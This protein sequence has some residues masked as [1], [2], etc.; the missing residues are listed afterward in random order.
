MTGSPRVAGRRTSS[1]RRASLSILA[2]VC[3]ALLC[4]GCDRGGYTRLAVDVAD[5]TWPEGTGRTGL[6]VVWLRDGTGKSTTADGRPMHVRLFASAA[7]ASTG[8]HTSEAGDMVGSVQPGGCLEGDFSWVLP[9]LAPPPGTVG[10][11]PFVPDGV[12]IEAAHPGPGRW[13]KQVFTIREGR[14]WRTVPSGGLRE[15]MGV[16]ERVPVGDAERGRGIEASWRIAVGLE[17]WV[18]AD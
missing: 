14:L 11:A 7:D 8:K 3:L 1:G 4:T 5:W 2:F 10:K 17:P 9:G 6:T 13:R 18:A 16:V 15:A 12:W